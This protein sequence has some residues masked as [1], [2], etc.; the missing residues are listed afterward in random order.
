MGTIIYI[1]GLVLAVMA[2]LDIF[3][4]NIST[5]WKIIW[6]ILILITSWIGLAVYYLFAKDRIEGWCK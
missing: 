6:T 3:K 2:V 4:K 5:P 1:V